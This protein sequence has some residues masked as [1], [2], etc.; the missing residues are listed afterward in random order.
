MWSVDRRVAASAFVAATLALAIPMA[1]SDAPAPSR[2]ADPL[3]LAEELAALAN[4]GARAAWIV[5]YGF[6]RVT[7]SRSRLHQ[8]IVTAHRP[9]DGGLD[10]DDGLGSLVVTA[11]NRTYSCTIPV[12]RPQCLVRATDRTSKPGAVYGGAVVS[13]RYDI[14]RLRTL[15]IA[16]LRARCFGLRLRTGRPVPGL[17]FSSQQCYSDTGVPLRSLVQGPAATDVRVASTVKRTVTRRDVLPILTAYGLERLAPP[18]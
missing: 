10:I 16:G 14:A 2:A 8:T 3:V 12:D 11:G 4:R 5:T 18:A 13:G 9:G 17:G 15:T 7:A 6:T 1:A